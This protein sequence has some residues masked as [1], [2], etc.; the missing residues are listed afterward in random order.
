[1]R[2]LI[3]LGL[4]LGL[5]LGSIA[6]AA[7]PKLLSD[8]AKQDNADRALVFVH[9]LLGD[10]TDSFGNWPQLIAQDQTELPDHGKISDFAVYSVDYQADFES[11]I[12]LDNAAVGVA[13]D[14][15]ASTIFRRHRH[16]WFVAHSMGG[17][18]L[19][20]V[21]SLWSL[22]QKS[23]FIDR[24]MAVVLLGVPSAG[25]PLA[26]F[27]QSY[28]VGN[29]ATAFGWNGGLLV[30]LATRGGSYL[31]S[32]E[33]NWTVLRRLRNTG[34]E[35]RFKPIFACG[36]E[37]K[38]EVDRSMWLAAV[39]LLSGRPDIGVIVPN[40]FA[41]S[42]EEP[43][44]FSVKHTE[45]IKP[46][47]AG[48]SIYI[49]LRSIITQSIVAA[50][51]E[52]RIEISTGPPS[53]E[54]GPIIASVA[55]RAAFMNKALDTAN[56][57]WA[58]GLPKDPERIVFADDQSAHLAQQLVLR[59]GSFRGSTKLVTWQRAAASNTCLVVGHSPNR[60]TISLTVKNAVVECPG[61]AIV[62][63]GKT[64]N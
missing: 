21:L 48:D 29:V 36:Y 50:G 42:C 20:R 38:P 46:K 44:H 11:H 14:L 2:W 60:L 53:S 5:T 27:L 26:D 59:D 3:A 58:T 19:K 61:G 63:Q 37:E 25:A 10:P 24:T 43:R 41:G 6:N 30:D 57:D 16:V 4:C 17:L 12:K 8:P 18:I 33:T 47:N 39:S 28:G 45:L 7:E 15:A 13:S 62:C 35:R 55:E 56:L 52:S 51:R 23:L 32:L 64:C 9:G 31:D 54:P 40:L 34:L 1:M 49:W 22:E